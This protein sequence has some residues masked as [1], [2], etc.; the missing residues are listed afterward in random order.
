MT[1]EVQSRIAEAIVERQGD[2]AK[3][4]DRCEVVSREAFAFILRTAAE[5]DNFGPLGYSSVCSLDGRSIR[6][7]LIGEKSEE[8]K[9]LDQQLRTEHPE[10]HMEDR[11]PI[12]KFNIDKQLADRKWRKFGRRMLEAVNLPVPH[13]LETNWKAFARMQHRRYRQET[14][15]DRPEVGDAITLLGINE[16]VMFVAEDSEANFARGLT[17]LGRVAL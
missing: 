7:V 11:S 13:F 12:E 14:A 8:D 6:T 15:L 5:S 4:Y 10:W 9:R 3:E 2:R 17:P 1:T 16:R